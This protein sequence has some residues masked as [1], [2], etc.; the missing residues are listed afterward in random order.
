M[1]MANGYPGIE[2]HADE[3]TA[4]LK[5]KEFAE[6]VREKIRDGLLLRAS[7]EELRDL[8]DPKNHVIKTRQLN[9]RREDM[10]NPAVKGEIEAAARALVT[11][12]FTEEERLDACDLVMQ[13]IELN[14][15]RKDAI[16]QTIGADAADTIVDVT[17]PDWRSQV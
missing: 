3:R 1:A 8:L 5:G 7:L 9:F 16:L 6:K 10:T 13:I 12:K 4:G 11:D 15:A 2:A 14:A 17:R